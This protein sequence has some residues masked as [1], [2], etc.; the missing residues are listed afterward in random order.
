MIAVFSLSFPHCPL[1]VRKL[2][3]YIEYY[4]QEVRIWRIRIP[5]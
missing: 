5:R 2:I 4:T 1:A 3:Q